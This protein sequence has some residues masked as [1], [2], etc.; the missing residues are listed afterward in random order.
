MTQSEFVTAL[1]QIGLLVSYDHAP[2]GS[3]V[4]YI[5]YKWLDVPALMAD[6]KVY[7]KKSEVSVDLVAISKTMANTY[8]ETLENILNEIAPWS[9]V[10]SYSDQEK[11]YILSYSME[12]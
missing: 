8:A 10:E 1:N 4:P 3:Q 11:I 12:V 2:I 6:N 5:N 9:V 7:I